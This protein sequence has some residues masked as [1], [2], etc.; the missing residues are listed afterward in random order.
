MDSK[1]KVNEIWIDQRFKIIQKISSGSFGKIYEGIDTKN[2]DKKVI[3]K[4]NIQDDM[5]EL[6]LFVLSKLNKKGFKNFPKLYSSGYYNKKPYLIMEKL[7]QT[8]E[9]YQ[10]NNIGKFS[11]KTVN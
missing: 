8:L 5:N 10:M 4:Q 6:E 9:Y 3:C 7:G 1:P 2:A 11:Y